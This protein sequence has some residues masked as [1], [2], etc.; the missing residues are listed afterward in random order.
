[1]TTIEK[2]FVLTIGALIFAGFSP[3]LAHAQNPDNGK[4]VWEEQSNC[5]NCHGDMGQGKWS[6][7]LVGSEKTADEWI[8]QVRTPKRAMPAFS[9]EQISDDQ[10]RDVFAYMATLPPPPE[11]FEFMPMDPGLAADAHPGQVLLAQKRCAACHSTDGPI[12]GFIKRAEMPTVEGVI[13]QVRTPFKY[14]PAF[15][16]EQVSDEELAQ[17]ADFVT[18]QVSAQMAPATLPTSG[19]T[20]P[21]PWPLALMLAGVAAVAGG[22]ALRGFVLRR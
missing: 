3:S 5:K 6:G 12:K 2:L 15:N 9:A 13:K 22:F 4:L 14:M 20:P 8:E 19:G 18:Q 17:I 7:P 1:M 21:N 11:D 16:A 10:I